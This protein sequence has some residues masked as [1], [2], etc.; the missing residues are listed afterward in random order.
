MNAI[1]ADLLVLSRLESTDGEAA[2][3]AIDVPNMLERFA[4]RCVS[5]AP[6]RLRA[7]WC[8]RIG[9]HGRIVRFRA[10]DRIRIHQ[11]AGERDEIIRWREAQVRM[12][13]WG[14]TRRGRISP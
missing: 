9:V 13:W 14:P 5:S 1:I 10:R 2:R 11:F 4:S 7:T 3:D 6:D 8:W 12:R